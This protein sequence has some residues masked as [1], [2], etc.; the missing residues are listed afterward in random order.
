M[1]INEESL[2]WEIDRNRSKITNLKTKEEILINCTQ[3][4]GLMLVDKIMKERN[5]NVCISKSKNTVEVRMNR[6]INITEIDLPTRV[7]YIPERL[8]TIDIKINC[9]LLHIKATK[10]T[11]LKTNYIKEIIKHKESNVKRLLLFGWFGLSSE[12]KELESKFIEDKNI[13]RINIAR[14][15]LETIEAI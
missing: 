14:K 6:L 11:I 2:E 3:Y 7:V 8:K 10:E 9:S 13:R 1:I 12:R 5:I 15:T 4:R